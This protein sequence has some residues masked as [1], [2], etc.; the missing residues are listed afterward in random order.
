MP[1]RQAPDSS[2]RACANALCAEH[3]AVRPTLEVIQSHFVMECSKIVMNM[4]R[5]P[6]GGHDCV[7]RLALLVQL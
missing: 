2:E 4:H 7:Y 6:S 3:Y 1:S 5:I